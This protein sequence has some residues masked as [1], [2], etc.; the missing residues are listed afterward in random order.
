M[1]RNYLIDNT[2]FIMI[3]LVVFGH[4][5]EPLIRSNESIKTVYMAIYSVHMP[6]FVMLTGLLSKAK[7]TRRSIQKLVKAIVVPFIIFTLL[8][9]V[10]H[11]AFTGFF[12]IYA[13][14]L[15]PFWLLWFLYSLVIWRLLL[16]ILLMFPYPV[17]LS[18]FISLVAGYIE[19]IGYFLGISRTLYFL[20]FFVFGYKVVGSVIEN[21]KLKQCPKIVYMIIL[22]LNGIFFWFVNNHPVEWL[23]GSLSYEKLSV[24]TWLGLMIRIVIYAISMIS[25][26]AIFMLITRKKTVFSSY[27]ANSMQVYLWHG[28][29]VKIALW[30]GLLTFIGKNESLV[31]MSILFIFAIFIT[32]ILSTEYVRKRT[33]R[34]IL[35]K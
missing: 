13:I 24:D 32:L 20:P 15:R 10:F 35:N 29:I 14:Q 21:K 3:V 22:F 19:S 17:L 5:V 23:Y 33:Q 31:T 4:L 16:P 9:E 27:G 18:V 26:I 12:S 25:S 11:L 6:I 8:Y 30:F 28:F 2:K 1:V 34:L 7:L